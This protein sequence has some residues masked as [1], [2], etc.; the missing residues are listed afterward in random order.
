MNYFVDH[1]PI[2]RNR[3]PGTVQKP[4]YLTIHSTGNATSTAKNERDWLINPSNRRTASWHIVVDHNKA[5]EAIPLNEVAYHAGTG[6]GNNTSIGIEICE[7]GDR[8]KTLAN[9]ADLAASILQKFGWSVDRLRRHYDWSGKNCPRILR[10][11]NWAEWER[12]KK[13]V[14]ERLA[15]IKKIPVNVRGKEVE[16]IMIDT[17]SYVPVRIVS[18]KLGARVLYKDGKVYVD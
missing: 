6:A 2:S 1:I 8:A 5:I 7:S 13:E 18:E 9:A 15:E 4:Q 12:F 17:V 14:E 16:G 11:D 3:R 10:A